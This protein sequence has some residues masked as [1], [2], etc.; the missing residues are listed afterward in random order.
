MKYYLAA[1]FNRQAEMRA[2][3]DQLRTMGH[4]VTSRWLD[5]DEARA[6]PRL[7]H[8]NDS[9]KYAVYARRD[10][11]DVRAADTLVCFSGP[12]PSIGRHIEFGYAL[13]QYEDVY[14]VGER[15]TIFHILPDVIHYKTTEEFLM[16]QKELL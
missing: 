16:H 8:D 1:W 11:E 15:E 9:E 5:V 12:E 14:V 10:L 2:V 3:R 7:F 4:E 13:A 6:T